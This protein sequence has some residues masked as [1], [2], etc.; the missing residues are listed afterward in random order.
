MQKYYLGIDLGSVTSKAVIVNDDQEVVAS[1]IMPTESN[2][3]TVAEKCLEE[4]CRQ[5]GIKQEQL[6]F[7]IGT[8]Y[9]RKKIPFVDRDITEISCHA[10]GIAQTFPGTETIIDIGGQDTKVIKLTSEAKVANF[11]MNDKC[12][13]GTGRFLEVMAYS[14]K[15]T[16]PEINIL[17]KESACEIEISSICTVFAESEVISL[18][19]DGNDIADIAKA[20]FKSISSKIIAMTEKISPGVDKL[21]FTGGVAKNK[22]LVQYLQDHWNIDIKIPG[23]PQLTGALGAALHARGS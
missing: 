5:A 13:A 22:F 6:S 7:S 3:K 1:S 2:Y 11:M 19:A 18:K 9:G 15:Q 8:G 21:V 14:L 4:V 17:A 10:K 12:A 20:I 23:E 16:L